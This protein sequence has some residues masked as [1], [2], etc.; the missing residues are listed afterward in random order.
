MILC[1][2][3]F[4]IAVAGLAHRLL[5]VALEVLAGGSLVALADGDLAV[6]HLPHLVP[7]EGVA[8]GDYLAGVSAVHR[9]PAAGVAEGCPADVVP[10]D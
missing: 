1:L 2:I 10:A 6:G 3:V 7:V 5:A 4:M 8:A 9:H